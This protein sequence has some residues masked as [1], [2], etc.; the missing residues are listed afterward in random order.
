MASSSGAMSLDATTTTQ[1]GQWKWYH[2]FGF[3]SAVF[4]FLV[5]A[6]YFSSGRKWHSQ[7]KVEKRRKAQGHR[8]KAHGM[9]EMFGDPSMSMDMGGGWYSCDWRL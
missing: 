1:D 5:A 6:G 9:E 4:A 8:Q 7:I 3:G 2:Y